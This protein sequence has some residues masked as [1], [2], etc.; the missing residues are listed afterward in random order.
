M[1]N[2]KRRYHLTTL[3]IEG[4]LFDVFRIPVFW[5]HLAHCLVIGQGST[6]G[7][8]NTETNT[9]QFNSVL[10]INTEVRAILEARLSRLSDSLKY[11]PVARLKAN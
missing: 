11:M 3:K 8:W 1:T 9:W 4:I 7:L 2:E 10:P 5:P 6:E